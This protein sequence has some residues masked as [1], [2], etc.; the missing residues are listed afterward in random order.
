M[1]QRITVEQIK[2]LTKE[3]GNKLRTLWNPQAGDYMYLRSGKVLIVEEG[4]DLLRN[5][6]IYQH[7]LPLLSMGQM[8]EILE[9]KDQC[10]NITKKT[11]LEGWGYEIQLRQIDY[12]KF[13]TGELCDALFEAVKTVL[14]GVE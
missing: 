7:R 8:I 12:Y 5:K 14:E 10:L 9:S 3:Q 4:T 1:K 6:S 2:E 13:S 11:D